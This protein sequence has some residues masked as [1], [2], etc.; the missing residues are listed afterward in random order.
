MIC[1]TSQRPSTLIGIFGTSGAFITAITMSMLLKL[2]SRSHPLSRELWTR[3]WVVCGPSF[4]NALKKKPQFLFKEEVVLARQVAG[5]EILCKGKKDCSYL[6][7]PQG[8]QP[9]HYHDVV[10]PFLSYRLR[11]TKKELSCSSLAQHSK[12]INNI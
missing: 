5:T 6:T 10:V 12:K 9:K 2:L 8:E 1:F 11:T 7:H 3:S 4:K